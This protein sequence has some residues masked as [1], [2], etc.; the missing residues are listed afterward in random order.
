MAEPVD[1]EESEP[2][3]LSVGDV[4]ADRY[5][6]D[7]VLGEGGMGVVYRVE[8]LH[9]H[10]ALA[11]KALLPSLSSMPE[12]LARFEREAIAAGRIQDP[13]VAAATDFGRLPSGSLFLVM[14]YVKG[15]TLREALRD[16]PLRP[17]RA[18][19]VLRGIACALQAAHALG[20]VHR[21]VKPENIML[22]EREG[23]TDFVKVLDFG[24]AKIE[25]SGPASGAT[26]KVLTQVGAVIGTPSYMSP[27]QAL[28]QPVDGRSDLYSVG[29]LLFEMLAGHRPFRGGA[30]TQ[31]RHHVLTDVPELPAEVAAKVMPHVPVILKRLVAKL[32]H[33]RFAGAAELI[34]AIDDGTPEPTRREPP[35]LASGGRAIAA[36]LTPEPKTLRVP[37][38]VANGPE[39]SRATPEA[40]GSQKRRPW[41]AAAAVALLG[42]AVGVVALVL[43]G[44][45]LGTTPPAEPT[46][47][48]ATAVATLG[49][50]PSVV[51]PP[52][53]LPAPTAGPPP[54]APALAETATSTRPTSPPI[55]S[56]VRSHFADADET[57][58]LDVDNPGWPTTLTLV[59]KHDGREVARQG[60]HVGKAPR[61][62]TWGST[63][64]RGA[65]VI[66]VAV[67]DP[68]GRLL[69]TDTVTVGP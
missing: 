40:L 7:A 4:V 21:D 65:R 64:R 66:D 9:L 23:D 20:I 53:P 51:R 18:M 56:I 68:Q 33:E 11:L 37:E 49:P 28:G 50:G 24:I 45:G 62:R 31:L 60:L 58:W 59:W 43:G 27:E 35:T 48:S 5:R 17:E 41:L 39:T 69:K 54:T 16:G 12:V 32:P 3:S 57:Y 55:L 13:H 29:I 10:K 19:H 1:P 6:I 67:F 61:W 42:V 46:G 30:V 2:G 36:S 26:S 38:R 25:G 22:V 15:P 14:E 8:H 63:P 47:G 44:V 34:A 52:P